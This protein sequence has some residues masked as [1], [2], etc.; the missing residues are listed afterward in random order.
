MY[1]VKPV[2]DHLIQ[3]FSESYISEDQPS[4]D[5]ISYYNGRASLD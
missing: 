5:K 3:I 4:V 1:K 2:F